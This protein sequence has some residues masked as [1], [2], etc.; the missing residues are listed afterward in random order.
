M[1][2]ALSSGQGQSLVAPDDAKEQAQLA[3]SVQEDVAK[4]RDS[5]REGQ[6]ALVSY[7]GCSGKQS[8]A[9]CILLACMSATAGHHCA[10]IHIVSQWRL[11]DTSCFQ[12]ALQGQPDRRASSYDRVGIHSSVAGSVFAWSA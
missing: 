12:E 3:R 11:G 1:L 9:C 7:T 8:A 10:V 2:D 4:A 5:L 6:A